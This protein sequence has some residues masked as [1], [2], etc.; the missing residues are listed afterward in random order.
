[1]A[2]GISITDVEIK[3]LTSAGLEN[4]II[5]TND[6][7]SYRHCGAQIVPDLRSGITANEISR[8]Q[9]AFTN[10]SALVAVAVASDFLCEP[11]CTAV[12][13]GCEETGTEG[14]Q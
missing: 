5:V 11:L 10:N 8:L 3:Q 7:E 4:I 13:N 1:M 14:I 9:V 12:H 6:P 2:E